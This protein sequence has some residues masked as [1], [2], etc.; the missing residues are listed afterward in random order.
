P[1]AG[2][3]GPFPGSGDRA[4]SCSVDG[5]AEGVRTEAAADPAPGVKSDGGGAG[6]GVSSCGTLRT[7]GLVSG[8]SLDA[9][10]ADAA[11][12]AAA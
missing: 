11:G 2:P 3:A 10:A 1:A 7:L 4:A 9:S 5:G 8:V 12:A 6:R